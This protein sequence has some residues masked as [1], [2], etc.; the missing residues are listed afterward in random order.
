VRPVGAEVEVD[1]L[2]GP[3][4]SAELLAHLV[5]N[6]VKVVEY[7]RRRG[8]LEDAFMRFTRGDVS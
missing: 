5:A 1:L 8:G 6:G 3:E 4:E 2:G 7:R